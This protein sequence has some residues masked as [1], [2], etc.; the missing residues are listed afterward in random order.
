MNA[1]TINFILVVFTI[2]IGSFAVLLL[3]F[4]I[5][6]YFFIQ[7]SGDE[8]TSSASYLIVRQHALQFANGIQHCSTKI[9]S[10]LGVTRHDILISTVLSNED[11]I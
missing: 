9:D 2:I 7:S 11:L 3:L 4:Y 1:F 8:L 5:M 10:D 6:R